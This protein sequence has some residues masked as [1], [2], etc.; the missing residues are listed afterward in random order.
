MPS[1]AAQL[2]VGEQCA[3]LVEDLHQR[4]RRLLHQLDP[5]AI[6]NYVH[7]ESLDPVSTIEVLLDA[8][9]KFRGWAENGEVIVQKCFD[10][11]LNAFEE[12]AWEMLHIF[13]S[14]TLTPVNLTTVRM[15][16]MEVGRLRA[17]PNGEKYI[18]T[19]NNINREA[20]GF[21]RSLQ[22]DATRSPNPNSEAWQ[23]LEMW[24]RVRVA[25]PDCN[26]RQCGWREDNG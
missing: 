3:D 22:R 14:E 6:P 15:L 20:R 24:R 17:R 16:A 25:V 11:K 13:Y 19:L 18:T 4:L 12:V 7:T 21:E 8:I 10:Q 2:A 9:S 23:R 5:A 1:T 26:C